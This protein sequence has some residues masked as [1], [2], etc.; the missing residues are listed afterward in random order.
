MALSK[1]K[2]RLDDETILQK[3][4]AQVA[5]ATTDTNLTTENERVQRYYDQEYPRQQNRGSSPYCSSDVFDGVESM[6]AQLLETF[7]G[8]T[9]IIR[10]VPNDDLEAPVVAA[11][12]RYVEHVIH[13]QNDSFDLFHDLIDDGLKARKG[14]VQAYWQEDYVTDEHSFKGMKLSDVEALAAQDGVELEAD[15]EKEGDLYSEP[16][17]SGKW[18]RKINKCQIK[19]ENVPPEEFF[20][21]A[22]QKC[23]EDGVRGRKMMKTRAALIKD[24]YDRDKVNRLPTAE[25]LKTSME[26]LARLE[27]TQNTLSFADDPPQRE[28]EHVQLCE[29]YIELS[30]GDD[31]TSSLYKVVHGDNALFSCEEVDEDPFVT[32]EPLRRPHSQYGNNFAARIIPTQV[33]RTALMRGILDHTAITVN[34]RWQVLNGAL[35]NPREMLDNRLG[36]IVNVRQRDGIAP[37]Q[38]PNLNPFVFEALSMLKDNKEENTGISSLSQGLNKDAI[39]SQNSQGLVN[40]L[41]TLSQVRQK[42]IARNFAKTITELYLKVRKLV[43]EFESR[44]RVASIT[45][46]ENVDP[47]LWTPE[48]K[49]RTSLHIGYGEQ[50]KE[51]QKFV[52][53]WQFLTQDPN[54]AKFCDTPRQ[55]KLL[56]DGMRKNSFANFADYVMPPEQVPPP[57]PDP[58][59]Q[60]K[61]KELEIKGMQAEA[62]LISAKAAQAKVA[63]TA[64]IEQLKLMLESMNTK[65]DQ[66]I[67]VREAD[68]QD[69]DVAN[70]VDVSQRETEVL[71][72]TPTDQDGA[73]VIVSPNS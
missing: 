3:V 41:V 17:Y 39:S 14:V 65:F 35:P 32:F 42:I 54:A 20:F 52:S 29:T 37:L 10:F 12:T 47:K 23:R 67:K 56:T 11:E 62:A 1:K 57:Q 66:A 50:E 7:V 30:L 33:A 68:R 18:A 13:E 26:R 6:K 48:R 4:N 58:E 34:P 63:A 53:A 15:M 5:K 16:T 8:S 22:S 38:Y 19:V 2:K 21:D 73:S 43:I 46:L 70:R 45:D 44:E 72:A 49:V 27:A 24:G 60:L 25:E 9:D 28:L 55:Y 71:E 51:A 40:D 64:E 61:M 69:L 36:G 59:M 31:G